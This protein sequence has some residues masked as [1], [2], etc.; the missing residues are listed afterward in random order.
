[1]EEKLII[2]VKSPDECGDQACAVK[3]SKK[4]MTLIKQLCAESNRSQCDVASRLIEFAFDHT[5]VVGNGNY[6][7]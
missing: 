7:N 4:A 6:E 1:M 2:P 3:V 5:E